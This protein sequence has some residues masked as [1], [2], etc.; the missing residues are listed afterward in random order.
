MAQAVTIPEVGEGKGYGA[1]DAEQA[2]QTRNEGGWKSSPRKV[3]LGIVAFVLVA[4]GVALLAHFA[5]SKD[6]EWTQFEEYQ[7]LFSKSY[8]KSEIQEKFQNFKESLK[9]IRRLRQVE[10]QNPSGSATFGVTEF[11]DLSQQEF[12]DQYL[13]LNVDL[14][15]KTNLLRDATQGAFLGDS[16]SVTALNW[17]EEGTVTP[18]RNQGSCGSCWAFACVGVV[19]SVYIEKD[20]AMDASDVEN[21]HLSVQQMVSCDETNY[22]C[23]GGWPIDAME[24]VQDAGGLA[25]EEDYPYKGWWAGDCKSETIVEGTAPEAIGYGS[26]CDNYRSCDDMDEEGLAAS[27]EAKGPHVVCV[28][29]SPWQYYTGGVLSSDVCNTSGNGRN[30]LNHAVILTGFDIGDEREAGDFE[31]Q[32]WSIKNSWSTSWG[33]DGY[34]H[35]EYGANTCGIANDA[36]YVEL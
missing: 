20:G 9:E 29:A 33:S 24:Y 35:L 3:A 13:G 17:T 4:T 30:I 15:A 32:Y 34:I 8:S 36:I 7:V 16:P 11:A 5:G 14:T 19:E 27:V 1:V 23:M 6:E 18:V 22:G 12:A 21:F 26:K 10:A 25:M 2:E 31:T 28:N